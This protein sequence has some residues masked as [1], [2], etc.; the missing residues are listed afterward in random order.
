MLTRKKKEEE[1][2]CFTENHYRRID[3][4]YMI[5]PSSDLAV[6]RRGL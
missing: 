3:Y 1:K 2:Q 4:I 5:W 6:A